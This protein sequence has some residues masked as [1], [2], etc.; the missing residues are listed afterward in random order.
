M[1]GPDGLLRS[2]VVEAGEPLVTDFYELR[3]V[4]GHIAT[5]WSELFSD[6]AGR[7]VRLVL[8]GSGAFD[9]AGVTLL[10]TAS[11]ERARRAERRRVASTG[12]ASG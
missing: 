3:D 12:V 5:G 1:H 11:T 10:G 2:D 6:I 7:S 8:G 9:V 4:P